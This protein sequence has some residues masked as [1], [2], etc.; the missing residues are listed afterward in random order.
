MTVGEVVDFSKAG[1]S[2]LADLEMDLDLPK[3][4][5]KALLFALLAQESGEYNNPNAMSHV[6]WRKRTAMAQGFQRVMRNV[7]QELQRPPLDNRRACRNLDAIFG[8]TDESVIADADLI[9]MAGLHTLSAYWD[10]GFVSTQEVAPMLQAA[11]SASLLREQAHAAALSHEVVIAYV[12]T[13]DILTHQIR[14]EQVE[15]C[16]LGDFLQPFDVSPGGPPTD[17]PPCSPTPAA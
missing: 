3:I 15:A 7:V 9:A 5:Q 2:L 4:A 14:Y 10:D 6:Q 12:S 16:G 17:G 13:N 11:K 1:D 8:L